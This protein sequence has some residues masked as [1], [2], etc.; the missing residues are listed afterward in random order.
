MGCATGVQSS[1]I[2]MVI[3]MNHSEA[4][5]DA[6]RRSSILRTIGGIAGAIIL[7]VIGNLLTDWLKETVAAQGFVLVALQIIQ[8][9]LYAAIVIGVGF[10]AITAIVPRWRRALWVPAIASVGRWWP[11]TNARYKRDLD[12][13]DAAG[14]DRRSQ[15]VATER[16]RTPK[17]NLYVD[18][19]GSMNS[20]DH[21]FMLR[22]SGYPVSDIE[23][24]TDGTDLVLRY[25]VFRSG[26]F[27]DNM[28]GGV[29]GLPFEGDVTDKGRSSGVTFNIAY[30]DQAGDD[31]VVQYRL[32]PERLYVNT[33]ETREEAYARGRA[34]VQSEIDAQRTKP[35]IEPQWLLGYDRKNQRY[36]ISNSAAGSTARDVKISASPASF[37]FLGAPQWDDISVPADAEDPGAVGTRLFKGFI[38][39]EGRAFGV[40]V[41]VS[42]SDENGDRW[43]LPDVPVRGTE[44]EY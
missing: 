8:W 7:G 24:T 29:K 12:A 26:S 9:V 3:S 43:E 5:P 13:A 27:G 20:D 38:G 16:A 19:Q 30:T 32:A 15:E 6:P 40:R 31:H 28:P 41:T 2:A 35:I 42:W 1:V 4:P 37:A 11:V 14:Y 39:D 25:P 10:L 44:R 17:P 36:I 18:Q 33:Q 22:N 34:D 21:H 23:V